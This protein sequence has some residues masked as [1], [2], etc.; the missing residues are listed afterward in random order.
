MTLVRALSKMVF[1]CLLLLPASM[2]RAQEEPVEE[3]DAA[4]EG[5]ETDM[6]PD[7]VAATA[8]ARTS[9]YGIGLRARYVAIPT[10]LLNLFLD[11]STAMGHPGIALEAVRRKGDFDI[12]LGLE[13]ENIS[14]KDGLYL[15]KGDNPGTPGEYPD[16]VTFDGLALLGMDISF[17]W[18][19]KFHEKVSLRYGAGIGVG[20]VLGDVVQADTVCNPGTSADDLDDPKACPVDPRALPEK[21]D[22]VPPVV[23]IVNVLVGMRFKVTDRIFVNLEGGFRNMFYGGIGTNYMF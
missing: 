22:D 3:S 23:P 1:P 16:Y 13:Y 5:V 15:E 8:S 11:H 18:H 20:F 4:E 12:V 17:L 7:G 19:L 10:W 9:Q 6:P 21:S 2:A 14:P